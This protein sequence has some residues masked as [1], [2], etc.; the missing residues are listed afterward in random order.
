MTGEEHSTLRESFII[1]PQL[2]SQDR[3]YSNF[4]FVYLCRYGI[5]TRLLEAGL[6]PDLYVKLSM[7]VF[8]DI[9]MLDCIVFNRHPNYRQDEIIVPHQTTLLKLID[10]YLQSTTLTS[11]NTSPKTGKAH[12]KL[13][14]MLGNC[15]FDMSKYARKAIRRALGHNASS[16]S[17]DTPDFPVTPDSVE[18]KSPQLSPEY[19]AELDVMLPKVCEALVLVTQCIITITLEAEAAFPGESTGKSSADDSATSAASATDSERNL[20]V[21]FNEKRSENRGAVECLV[22]AILSLFH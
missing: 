16:P 5:F 17:Y 1:S 2:A 22:G 3:I 11:G 8:N 6:V 12:V 9:A 20:K 21:Y 14:P 13:S 18:L 19:P 4:A 7:Y 10:S 15:F